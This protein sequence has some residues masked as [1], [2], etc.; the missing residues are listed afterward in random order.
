MLEVNNGIVIVGNTGTC[1][2]SNTGFVGIIGIVGK[3]ETYVR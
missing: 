1:I 2:V 3:K